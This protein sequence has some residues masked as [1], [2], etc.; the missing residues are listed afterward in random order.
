MK[1]GNLFLSAM[2]MTLISVGCQSTSKKFNSGAQPSQE[3]NYCSAQQMSAISTIA[4]TTT[5]NAV[6]DEPSMDPNVSPVPTSPQAGGQPPYQP[7]PSTSVPSGN[8]NN[9]NNIPS[10]PG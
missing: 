1:S 9:P 3:I 6:G 8:P 7:V 10:M 4:K 2:A 5:V